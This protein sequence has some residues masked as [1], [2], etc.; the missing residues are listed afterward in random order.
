MNLEVLGYSRLQVE[1]CHLSIQYTK[2]TEKWELPSIFTSEFVIVREESNSH[3]S[4]CSCG[5]V[6]PTIK[7]RLEPS[8][9]SD[10]KL[11]LLL[12][13]LL[14]LQRSIGPSIIRGTSPSQ[15]FKTQG[16]CV[17]VHVHR[18]MPCFFFEVIRSTIVLGLV[19]PHSE[20]A[21]LTLAPRLKMN[22]SLSLHIPTQ[23]PRGLRSLPIQ[24]KRLGALIRPD[25]HSART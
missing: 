13:L 21:D 8:R 22:P 23:P 2:N 24:Q 6:G 17:S 20:L 7:T 25:E 1:I 14:L 16:V 11:L 5:R 15:G 19:C 12:L 9:L 10:S 4:Q 18:G 3:K